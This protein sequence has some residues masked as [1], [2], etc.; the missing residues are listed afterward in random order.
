[1]D[2]SVSE[3]Y[4]KAYTSSGIHLKWLTLTSLAAISAINTHTSNTL[5]S[6]FGTF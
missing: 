2:S 6:S 1:M 5:H 3:D 4:A